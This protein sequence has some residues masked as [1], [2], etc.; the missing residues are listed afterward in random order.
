[1]V[2]SLPDL[3]RIEPNGHERF[4]SNVNYAAKNGINWL[5]AVLYDE[6]DLN[7][8]HVESV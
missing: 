1:M 4:E 2:L 5:D 8:A 6:A 3:T 7:L